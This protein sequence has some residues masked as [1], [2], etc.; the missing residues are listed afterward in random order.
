MSDRSGLSSVSTSSTR[1][2]VGDTVSRVFVVDT[3][4]P[5][6]AG[7][8]TLEETLGWVVE[9]AN[10]TIPGSDM[11]SVTMLV[12]G[13]PRTVAFTD[14]TAP[15][16]D[17]AQYLTGIG[18][19]L[20]AVRCRQAQRVDSTDDAERWPP[21]AE[22]AAAHGILSSLSLPLVARHTAVGALNCY[23]RRPAAF[24]D[25]D[26][27]IGSGFAAAATVALVSWDAGH[28]SEHL[29]VAMQSWA[30]IEQAKGIL[31]AEQHCDADQ[32]FEMLVRASRQESRKL[33]D[34]ADQ[35]VKH[36]W[37]ALETVQMH[38]PAALTDLTNPDR[39]RATPRRSRGSGPDPRPAGA[40]RPRGV[41]V[42]LPAQR[43]A[44][45]GPLRSG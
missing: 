25:D 18:P 29:G 23:S 10:E 42:G 8:F 14:V 34:I 27:R 41:Q 33:R 35:I 40:K 3:V 26:E 44:P 5:P 17:D 22:A 19:C 39:R 31:I 38:P 1:V 37:R 36:C 9:L 15:E 13:R 12:E 7:D 30:T 11:V 21:F 28:L 16:L 6:S 2:F 20:D 4:S 45:Q 43:T 24:S 32:A